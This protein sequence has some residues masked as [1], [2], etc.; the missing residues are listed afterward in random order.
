M[1]LVLER[2]ARTRLDWVVLLSVLAGLLFAVSCENDS[3]P[4]PTAPSTP[5]PLVQSVLKL[6]VTARQDGR[7]IE[8]AKVDTFF[9]VEASAVCSEASLPCP[10]PTRLTWALSG[11][12][13]ETL[14][15]LT[16]PDIGVICVQTGIARITATSSDL[17]A[18]GTT[19]IQ[20]F[21]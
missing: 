3:A 21:R 14:G 17:N 10:R 11:A 19:Q 18:T 2:R 16:Q 12:F 20:V 6:A 7:I 9:T 15:D 13:C 1:P 8:Q 5:P 4:A